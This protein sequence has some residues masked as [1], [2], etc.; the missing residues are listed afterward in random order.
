MIHIETNSAKVNKQHWLDFVSS[1]PSGNIFQ[2]PEM[3][4]MYRNTPL[5]TP[6]FLCG[7]DQN[8]DIVFILVAVIQKEHKGLTGIFSARSIIVGG[9]LIKDRN[10][11][12][13]ELCL[14][15]YSKIIRNRAIYTQIR[16]FY[17]HNQST[18]HIFQKYGFKY[19]DHL[20]IV[21]SIS[22]GENELFNQFSRSR[23]KGI[24][25][26]DHHNFSFSE[27]TQTYAVDVFYS[28]LSIT[29][30]KIKLP[31]PS[32]KHF[33]EI[34]K[35]FN[36]NNFRIFFLTKDEQ[37]IA[38]LFVLNFN[39]T[40]YGYY[41]GSSNDNEILKN[42]PLDLLF[43]EVFKWGINH[44]YSFFDWM[45]AGKPDE[46]YGVR[47]FKLQYGG[48]AE[49]FGRYMKVHFPLLMFFSKNIFRIWQKLMRVSKH[50]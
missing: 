47:D 6:V 23:R 45:G 49:N 20:N 46:D 4:E 8:K 30:D 27:S 36:V 19:E 38:S 31:Y 35:I 22:V 44:G 25:K 1:H 48:N 3:Y 16:N 21:L 11:D 13:L 7:N 28:L 15:S 14:K 12:Y 26:A 37:Q 41:M 18:K 10:E 43:W 39:K 33:A 50:T 34:T 2:T 5:Y 9:P 42:K 24:K 32:K 40:I 17:I 29:Y